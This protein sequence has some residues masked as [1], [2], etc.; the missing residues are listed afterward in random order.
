M[1][2]SLACFL[3]FPCA[4]VY[5]G[6][7]P[8]CACCNVCRAYGCIY[9]VSGAAVTL[10]DSRTSPPLHMLL[11]PPRLCV[12]LGH[13]IASSILFLASSESP[14]VMVSTSSMHIFALASLT[15][16]R[17]EYAVFS[18]LGSALSDPPTPH[19][20]CT[21][22]HTSSIVFCTVLRVHSRPSKFLSLTSTDISPN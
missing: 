12:V 5:A 4:S 2:S 16:P 8:R 9:L 10:Y 1:F 3:G 18:S 14:H 17:S 6:S 22:L 7:S 19:S 11:Q 21:A 15:H 13:S 20:Y